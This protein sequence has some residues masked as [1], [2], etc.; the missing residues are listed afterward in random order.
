MILIESGNDFDY[1][2]AMIITCKILYVI[3]IFHFLNYISC[4]KVFKEIHTIYI[5]IIIEMEFQKLPV[6]V[7][8][9]IMSYK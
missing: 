8:N 7:I 3:S 2:H 5:N 4:K 9:N 6:E 1:N